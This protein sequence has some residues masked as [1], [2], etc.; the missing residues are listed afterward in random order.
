VS[1]QIPYISY[2]QMTTFLDC[3]ELFR[4]TRLEKVPEAPAWWLAG[5]TAVHAAAD[6][7]DHAL[8][9]AGLT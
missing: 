7:I 9:E 5:G 2:S 4:L 3:Q 6:A 8:I 1:E